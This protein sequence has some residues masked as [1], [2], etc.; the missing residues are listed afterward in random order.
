MLHAASHAAILSYV[1]SYIITLYAD[2]NSEY[3]TDKLHSN[4]DGALIDIRT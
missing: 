1:F 3:F 2:F 4:Y